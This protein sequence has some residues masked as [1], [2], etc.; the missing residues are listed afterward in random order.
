M[1]FER[2]TASATECVNE[3]RRPSLLGAHR[4]QFLVE[5]FAGHFVE[6]P[7]RLV[8]EEDLGRKREGPGEGDAHFLTTGKLARV[9]AVLARQAYEA[10]A[11]SPTAARSVAGTPRQLEQ[12]LHV[13][14]DRQP[15]QQGGFLK[16]VGQFLRGG[17]GRLAIDYQ[18][19][20]VT[21]LKPASRRRT[22]VLPQP[23]GPI[24]PTK[25]S[26]WAQKLI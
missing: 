4:E 14:V 25:S 6:R 17:F 20:S 15:G 23:L 24:R 12:Q 22:V 2:N 16:D 19:A 7:E 8:E 26:G 13:F 1:R 21:A 9:T 3:N 10:R 18:F 5:V 11:R